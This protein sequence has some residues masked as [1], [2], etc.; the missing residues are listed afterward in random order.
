MKNISTHPTVRDTFFAPLTA[1]LQRSTYRRHCNEFSDEQFLKSGV[2]RVI[3]HVFSGRDWVQRL[4]MKSAITVSVSNF[5]AALRS[6]RRL[7]MLDE[8]VHDVRTQADQLI[9]KSNDPLM[10][11]PELDGVAVYA[12]DGHTHGASAHEKE[13]AGKKRP[14]THIYSLNLRTQTL[15]PLALSTPQAYKKKEH[16]LSTLKRI[17]TEALRMKAPTGTRVIHVYDPAIVDYRQWYKWKQGNGIYV[18]TVE[19]SNSALTTIG[20]RE[21]DV[22]DPRNTGIVSD[23]YVGPSNGVAIRRVTYVDPVTGNTFRFLTNVFNLPPGLIA[24]LYKLRWDV[25]KV[26][27]QIKNKTLEQKAWAGNQ[28]AKQQN[29]MFI[30]LAHNLMKMLEVIIEHQEGITNQIPAPNRRA[31]LAKEIAMANAAGRKPNPLVINWRRAS[32]ICLQFIRWLRCVLDDSTS[33]RPAMKT[34][35]PLMEEYLK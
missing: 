20:K 13:I 14:V 12:T 28:T 30:A 23:E 32:Q 29:A 19:K 24:F 2:G 26:F 8:I 16:E 31:R 3:E 11:H 18:L 6:D 35:R 33:W 27:D 25:E 22:D 21:W 17:G 10:V 34:L 1:A 9:A 7:K 5:F 15:L 4:R